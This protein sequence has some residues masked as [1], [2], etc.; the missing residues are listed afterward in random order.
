MKKEKSI[1]DTPIADPLPLLPPDFPR[2]DSYESCVIREAMEAAR[3]VGRI[4]RPG[5]FL[6]VAFGRVILLAQ[7]L[8]RERDRL[9]AQ[10]ERLIRC[11]EGTPSPVVKLTRTK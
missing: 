6:H 4:E 3:Y 1:L 10:N 8:R 2:D 9:F 7:S 5:S 11:L